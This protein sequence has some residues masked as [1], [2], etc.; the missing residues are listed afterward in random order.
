MLKIVSIKF[1]TY[2]DDI[3]YTYNEDITYTRLPKK[4]CQKEN[5]F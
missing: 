1:C 5:L 4:L 3:T 2:C